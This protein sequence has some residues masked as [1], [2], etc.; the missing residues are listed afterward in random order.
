[1]TEEELIEKAKTDNIALEQ[2][3]TNYEPM[4]SSI[5]KGVKVHGYTREDLM[6]EARMVFCQAVKKY[7]STKSKLSTFAYTLIKRR[8]RDLKKAESVLKRRGT[9]VSINLDPEDTEY[10][11]IPSLNPTPEEKVLMEEKR[12]EIDTALRGKLTTVE[13]DVAI[14][15]SRGYTYRDIATLMNITTKQVD[16]ALQR[17]RNKLKG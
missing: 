8:L 11:D 17:A 15:F 16:N 4:I 13:F 9:V 14:L 6:Q 3:L 10:Y 1:M 12:Q 7:D 5:V 2:L